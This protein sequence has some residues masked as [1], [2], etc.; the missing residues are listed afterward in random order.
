M[1]GFCMSCQRKS[2]DNSLNWNPAKRTRISSCGTAGLQYRRKMDPVQNQCTEPS[3]AQICTKFLTRN[4]QLQPAGV[5]SLSK[6]MSFH[7]LFQ[8]TPKP[9]LT[10]FR[11]GSYSKEDPVLWCCPAVPPA[12]SLFF[13]KAGKLHTAPLGWT[14]LHEQSVIKQQELLMGL[15]TTGC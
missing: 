10:N 8:K 15:G 3:A 12:L 6:T 13:W 9:K 1:Q 5:T 2:T 11:E 7:G 14:L 4:P